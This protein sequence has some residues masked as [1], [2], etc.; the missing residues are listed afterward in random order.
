MLRLYW[1][2][3]HFTKNIFWMTRLE[4]STLA[5]C[6]CSQ[7]PIM[8]AGSEEESIALWELCAVCLSSCCSFPYFYCTLFSEVKKTLISHS[9]RGIGRSKKR[10]LLKRSTHQL[11]IPF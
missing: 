4:T 1:R 3:L 5:D 9:M 2:L 11:T 7:E 8:M 10:M 6:C